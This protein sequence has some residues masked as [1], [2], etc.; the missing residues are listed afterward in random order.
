MQAGDCDGTKQIL[1]KP[2]EPIKAKKWLTAQGKLILAKR[3]SSIRKRRKKFT[4][5]NNNNY[6]YNKMKRKK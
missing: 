3:Y 5:N 6:N 1:F 4:I 2:N